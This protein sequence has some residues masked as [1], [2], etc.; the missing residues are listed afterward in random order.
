MQMFVGLRLTG[1]LVLLTLQATL[2]GQSAARQPLATVEGA[3]ITQDDV[4][5]LVGAVLWPLEDR[6]YRIQ[7]QAVEAL[8]KQRLLETEAARRK[9]SLQALIDVEVTA[10]AGSV[11][12][13]EIDR[14][15]ASMGQSSREEIRKALLKEKVGAALSRFVSTLER[16]SKVRVFLEPPR[17]PRSILEGKQS[18]AKGPDSAPVTIVEFTDFHCSHCREAEAVVR[19]VLSRYAVRLVH[20]D[21]PIDAIHPHAREAHEAARCAEA[22]GKFWSYRDHLFA[23]TPKSGP[24]LKTLAQ[25]ASLDTA[26]FDAC[27]AS[28]KGRA[29]VEADIADAKRLGI[30]ATP[31]F[32]VNGRAL[33][34]PATLDAFVAAVQS[35]LPR[36]SRSK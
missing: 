12:E 2:T 21:L 31:T 29:A 20:R 25:S 30:T 14:A 27:V 22:Q 9:V 3:A 1:L 5:N 26:A 19:Q 7:Q 35:Q 13:E 36:S 4:D 17:V 10:R 11:T 23:G 8:I 15:K 34:G 24:D 6:L 28:G 16:K 33:E 32:F 18:P